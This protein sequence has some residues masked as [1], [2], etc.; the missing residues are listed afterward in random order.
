MG[1]RSGL[2]PDTAAVISLHATALR[3]V[4]EGLTKADVVV[5]LR[6]LPGGERPDL[7]GRAAGF[8]LGSYLASPGTS[9][10]L[11]IDAAAA[12]LATGAAPDAVRGAAED[13]RTRLISG[14]TNP[15]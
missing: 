15:L 11:Q 9:D 3:L 1:A 13:V 8:L 12:L 7:V 5:Q 2:D 10:P 4:R 6:A 14:H